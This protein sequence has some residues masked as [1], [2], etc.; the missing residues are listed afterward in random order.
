MENECKLISKSNKYGK[1][2]FSLKAKRSPHQVNFKCK[3]YVSFI[4]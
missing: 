3:N 2:K 1:F 4:R